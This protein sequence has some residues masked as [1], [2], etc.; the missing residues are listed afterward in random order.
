MEEQKYVRDLMTVGVPT[1]KRNT[2]LVDIARFLIEKHVEGMCVL[3]EDGNGVGVVG[4]DELVKA[5]GRPDIFELVAEDIMREGMPTLPADIPLKLAAALMQD[6]NTRIA[7]LIHNSAGII[8]PAAYITYKHLVR[9]LAAE[10]DDEL[11][12]LGLRAERELPLDSY[13]KRRNAAKE[14]N[15]SNK[16]QE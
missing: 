10:N 5:Y 14:R 13:I 8:Y 1:C 3:V 16:S 2:F 7:Y 15:L 6:Q 11:K 4:L 9:Y 12:D